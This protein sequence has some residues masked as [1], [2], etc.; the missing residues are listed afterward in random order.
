MRAIVKVLATEEMNLKLEMLLAPWMAFASHSPAETEKFETTN[1]SEP[2]KPKHSSN[3]R[4]IA[5]E[6][7]SVVCGNH[8]AA[9]CADCPFSDGTDYGAGW[10]NGDCFWNSA[11]SV[12]QDTAACAPE[13][14]VDCGGHTACSC[15]EC[16]QGNG[17][18]WCNGDCWWND[19][20]SA[21]EVP[22]EKDCGG[23]VIANGKGHTLLSFDLVCC[24]LI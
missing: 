4:R 22:T 16:P 19:V 13:N 3:Q 12:C 6:A 10:C 17:A 20:T 15:G 1:I 11:T 18:G 9:T 2:P 14:E 5:T 21:C 24:L 23:G 8:N 7:S